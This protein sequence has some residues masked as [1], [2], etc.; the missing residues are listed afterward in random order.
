MFRSYDAVNS[1][2]LVS[3]IFKFLLELLCSYSSAVTPLT[4]RLTRWYKHDLEASNC[5][6]SNLATCEVEI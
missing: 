4:I 5:P 6:I 2:P 3:H 1:L